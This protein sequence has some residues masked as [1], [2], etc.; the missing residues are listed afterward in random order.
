MDNS[1]I[2]FVIATICAILFLVLV[3]CLCC[4]HRKRRDERVPPGPNTSPIFG[5]ISAI[6]GTNTIRLYDRLRQQYGDVFSLYVGEKLAVVLNGFDVINVALVKY[7][8]K[9]KQR[10]IYAYQLLT[11]GDHGMTFGE[12]KYWQCRRDFI[13]E[14][15]HLLSLDISKA[16]IP[17]ETRIKMEVNDLVNDL[18]RNTN[19]ALDT[20]D[21]VI[22]SLGNVLF[23]MIFGQRFSRNEPEYQVVCNGIQE[24]TDQFWTGVKNLDGFPWL[25]NLPGNCLKINE[26]IARIEEKYDLYKLFYERRL[27]KFDESKIENSIDLF[28][29]KSW[30]F[31][32]FFTLQQLF[33]IQLELTCAVVDPCTEALQWLILHLLYDQ[34]LQRRLQADIDR[35]LRGRLPKIVDR[36][37]L[38][39]VRASVLETLRLRNPMPHGLPYTVLEDVDFLGYVIPAQ[40]VIIPNLSSIFRD[41]NT[42][43]DPDLFKPE[44]FLKADG[45]IFAP[46]EFVPFSLGQRS[47]LGQAMGRMMLFLFVTTLLQNFRFEVPVGY[48]LPKLDGS[49]GIIYRC[50]NY[51]VQIVDRNTM[52]RITSRHTF[53]NRLFDLERY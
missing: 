44:R 53:V 15:F 21:L 43:V 35:V 27:V 49:P 51:N 24:I 29:L 34:D 8:N 31:P 12:D 20:K 2:W 10:P 52:R 18:Q 4:V 36:E 39:L 25:H 13:M 48:Q 22:G 28:I 32:E 7:G 41:P 50:P 3:N 6:F 1:V 9:F 26:Q 17:M 37:K 47:C 5:N 33:A 46:P 14:A 16:V 45:K 30:E 23:G 40:T 42:F 38:P 19:V 11:N